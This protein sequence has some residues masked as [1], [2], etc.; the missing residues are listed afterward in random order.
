MAVHIS[1]TV[2]WQ[3]TAHPKNSCSPIHDQSAC[4]LDAIAT[5][6]THHAGLEHRRQTRRMQRAGMRPLAHCCDDAFL[7]L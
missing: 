4:C 1:T 6:C 3:F 5:P 7:K 2:D